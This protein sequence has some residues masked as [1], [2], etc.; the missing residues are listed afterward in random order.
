VV[1]G[2]EDHVAPPGGAR[3]WARALP[4]AGLEMVTDAGHLLWAERPSRVRETIRGFL[5]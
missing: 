2:E 3:E 5:A 4:D 1:H